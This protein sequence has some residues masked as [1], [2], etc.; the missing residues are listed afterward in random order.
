[1]TLTLNSSLM[2]RSQ[3]TLNSNLEKPTLAID[4][5]PIGFKSV[6]RWLRSTGKLPVFLQELL[7]QT[8]IEQ[9]LQQH[10]DLLVEPVVLQQAIADFRQQNSLE[11][12]QAFQ[13]WLV[14]QGWDEAIFEQ[15]VEFNLKLAALKATLAAPKLLE[16]FMEQKLWLDR[17]VLSRIVVESCDLA[18]ELNV[19]IE[20]GASFEQLAQEYSLAED[21]VTNGLMGVLHRADVHH[22]LGI[23]VYQLPLQQVVGAIACEQHWC[24]IRVEK[25]LPAQLDDAVK[26]YL[27]EQIFQQWLLKKIQ[28]QVVELCLTDGD[29]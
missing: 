29:E 6:L 25:L 18:E 7:S 8:V 17:V 16:A 14:D 10:P 12:N 13:H 28:T 5:H 20:E 4:H 11:D 9:E 24:L 19:Q 27:Q 23:D 21:A 22:W 3:P 15:H 1:M 26:E 2:E